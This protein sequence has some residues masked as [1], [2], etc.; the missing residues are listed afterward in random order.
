MLVT[1]SIHQN[2]RHPLVLQA[3]GRGGAGWGLGGGFNLQVVF[4]VA[5][6]CPA[7]SIVCPGEGPGRWRVV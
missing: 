2:A 6:H 3:G 1:T 4:K 7:S 5:L